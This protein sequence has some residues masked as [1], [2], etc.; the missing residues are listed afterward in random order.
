MGSPGILQLAT[1][2]NQAGSG[3]I[4]HMFW[5]SLTPAIEVQ[6]HWACGFSFRHSRS[7]ADL[8]ALDHDRKR[9]WK[10][11]TRRS[12]S[13]SHLTCGGAWACPNAHWMPP[14]RHGSMSPEPSTILAAF[15]AYPRQSS[16]R[17]PM[18]TLLLKPRQEEEP[19]S[20]CFTLSTK[21]SI[22]PENSSSDS[23]NW[24][25]SETL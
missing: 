9:K 22:L 24:M 19:P 21:A 8:R 17:P 16:I 13:N 6:I 4:T 1:M 25:P 5:I 3:S 12:V 11:K 20:T 14:I 15:H 23:R 18:L 7:W 2:E 10:R